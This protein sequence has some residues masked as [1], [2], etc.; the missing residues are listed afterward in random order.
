MNKLT[1]SFLKE[2]P[3][4]VIAR[5]DKGNTTVAISKDMYVQKQLELLNDAEVYEEVNRIPISK[6][7]DTNNEIVKLMFERGIID[8]REKRNLTT[9]TATEASMY[10]T[11]KHHKT[12]FPGRP[13][14]SN[15]NTAQSKLSKWLC[16]KITPIQEN[17]PFNIKNS[18]ELLT[19]LKTIK[20]EQ[21]EVLVSYDVVSLFTKLPRPLIRKVLKEQWRQIKPT[22]HNP[23]TPDQPSKMTWEIFERILD[24]C[25]EKSTYFS[26][27]GKKWFQ[28]K[29][30]AMGSSL[31]NILADFVLTKLLNDTFRKLRFKPKLAVKYVDDLLFVLPACMIEKLLRA[32]NAY[33]KD[34]DFTTELE[35]EGS[36]PFLDMRIIRNGD[37]ILTDWYAK[38]TSSGRILNFRSSHPM[39]LKI[40]TANGL[41]SRIFGLSSETFWEKNTT[42]ATQL[43]RKNEYP[44]RLIERIIRDTKKKISQQRSTNV[45]SIPTAVETTET[46]TPPPLIPD[47]NSIKFKS[48]TYVAGLTE[49]LQ[50]AVFSKIPDL[51]VGQKT[52]NTVGNT[53]FTKLKDKKEKMSTPNVIYRIPCN[54]CNLVYIGMTTQKLKCRV[55]N[56]KS[57]VKCKSITSS[58]LAEHSINLNHNI[59]FE[60]TDIIDHQEG[61]RRLQILETIHIKENENRCMNYRTDTADFSNIYASLIYK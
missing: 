38:P 8:A 45:A 50:A 41:A 32:L 39:R 26:S 47:T 4:I 23:T 7:E 1:K 14:V 36:L 11:I 37:N 58:A 12:G 16:D 52:S 61:W 33:H 56:H 49:K 30:C 28:K 13:V 24:F 10:L 9:Y 5:A 51:K 60:G 44:A 59:N 18:R 53:L 55:S 3:E 57:T 20:L 19:K 46:R 22:F 27:L 25:T 29:G 21:N 15:I 35:S 2:H 31:S 34:L 43:L 40:N 6:L 48:V 54:D 17:N 42:L